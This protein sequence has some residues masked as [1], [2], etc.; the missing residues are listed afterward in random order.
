MG[1]EEEEKI[2]DS[3]TSQFWNTNC[4]KGWEMM[5]HTGISKRAG[6]YSRLPFKIWI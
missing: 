3:Y 6:T 2:K 1:K 4:R 5:N